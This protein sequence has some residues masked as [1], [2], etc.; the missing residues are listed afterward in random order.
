MTIKTTMLT[1]GVR[2]L[3]ALMIWFAVTT[4]SPTSAQNIGVY[5]PGDDLSAPYFPSGSTYTLIN[6]ST[7]NSMTTADFAA[8]DIIWIEASL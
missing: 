1:A 7:W 2:A 6:E 4:P 5:G 3:G 8:Y